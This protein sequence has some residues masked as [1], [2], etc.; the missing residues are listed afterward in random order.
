[1][2]L[3]TSLVEGCEKAEVMCVSFWRMKDTPWEDRVRC[4]YWMYWGALTVM[5]VK[6]TPN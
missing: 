1:V 3:K 4:R 5:V 2:Q 6:D